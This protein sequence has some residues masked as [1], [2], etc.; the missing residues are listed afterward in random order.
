M[1]FDNCK[2]KNKLPF[3]FYLPDY[4]ICIEYDGLQH[5]ESIEYF[6]G[7]KNYKLRIEKDKIKTKYCQD[8][9]IILE[10]II[11]SDNIIEK[12]ENILF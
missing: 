4:N 9:N 12:L 6:G 10:R 3:D 2:Y 7:E 1:K 5:Y 11:Y 8:N